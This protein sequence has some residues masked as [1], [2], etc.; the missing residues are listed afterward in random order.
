MLKNDLSNKN[1]RR[2]KKTEDK[3][4]SLKYR[5]WCQYFVCDFVRHAP[6]RA[7]FEENP[8]ISFQLLDDPR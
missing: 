7:N 8:P 3:E 1:R 4:I 6:S 2:G 5:P